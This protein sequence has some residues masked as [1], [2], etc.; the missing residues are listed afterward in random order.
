MSHFVHIISLHSQCVSQEPTLIQTG[1]I[2]C[3]NTDTLSSDIFME[4]ITMSLLKGVTEGIKI[5]VILGAIALVI[6]SMPAQAMLF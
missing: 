1:L 2:I 4:G 5:L 6:M 3:P